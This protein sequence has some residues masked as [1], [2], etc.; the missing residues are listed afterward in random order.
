MLGEG[1]RQ[2]LDVPINLRQCKVMY[3][4]YVLQPPK[5]AGVTTVRSGTAEQGAPQYF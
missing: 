3:P 4:I 5:K 1:N 2:R